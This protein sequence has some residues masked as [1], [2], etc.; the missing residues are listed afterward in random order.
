MTSFVEYLCQRLSGE[1]VA[2][3]P[4]LEVEESH[5]CPADTTLAPQIARPNP[6]W[7]R[8]LNV[9]RRAEHN[10]TAR[11]VGGDQLPSAVSV[12]GRS[13]RSP[14]SSC[15]LRRL[16]GHQSGST[17]LAAV[18]RLTAGAS[19]RLRRLAG[20]P[21]ASRGSAGLQRRHSDA[22]RASRWCPLTKKDDPACACA[23]RGD[24]M[25]TSTAARQPTDIE[26][27]AAAR[28][29]ASPSTSARIRSK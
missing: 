24:V 13:G 26:P 5:L 9:R 15:S 12:A 8:E 16:R 28:P 18:L 20:Y 25:A 7:R 19:T 1:P 6:R 23:P 4:A 22:A 17:A 21:A 10:A 29:A 27:V 2:S 14:R 11:A 3:S